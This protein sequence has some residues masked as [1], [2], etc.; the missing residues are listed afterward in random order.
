MEKDINIFAGHFG[1]GKTEIA[2]NFALKS[3]KPV[4]IIDLDIVNPYFRTSDVREELVE[5]DISIIASDFASSNVDMPIIPAEVVSVFTNSTKTIVFDVGGDDDGA[6][7]L[8]R[9]RDSIKKLGYKMYFVVNAKRPMT[10]TSEDMIQIYDSIEV[11]SGLSF[12][13]IINNTNLGQDTTKEI[14]KNGNEEILRLSKA[15]QIPIVFES[16]LCENVS[17]DGF[18]LDKLYMKTPWD[19]QNDL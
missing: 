13:G 18:V 9:Y 19:R 4:T 5:N 2:I 3:E 16:G 10:K 1:S 14:L 6:Y 12:T 15:K 8:G 11:A 7:A 17:C